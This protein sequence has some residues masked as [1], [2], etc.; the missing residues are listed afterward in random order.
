MRQAMTRVAELIACLSI[1]VATSSYAQD[2]QISSQSQYVGIWSFDGS[3]ASGDGMSLNA[4]GTAGFDE[5]GTGTWAETPDG[6]RI[7]LILRGFEEMG[8][9]ANSIILKELRV[10][11]HSKE[12]LAGA[13]LDDG[14]EISA[15]LCPKV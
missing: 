13:F 4:D 10:D 11:S 7:V 1:F 6:K 3:C 9:P 5:W 14:R 2:W 12:K 15:R 8:A